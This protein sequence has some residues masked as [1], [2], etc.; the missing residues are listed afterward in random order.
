MNLKINWD[1]MGITTS[2]ACA[3]HC[4]LLPLFITSF[5]ILGIEIIDNQLFEYLMI[6]AAFCVGAY[7][8]FH[9]WKK[10]HHQ[11]QPLL[12]FSLGIGFLICKQIWHSWQLWFLIP[13]VFLIIAGH[14]IN[15]RLCRKANHCHAAD[16]SH[17]K[18]I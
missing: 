13:A 15:Y 6:F 10:H 16:C 9:G 5:P 12:L 1:A 4:A 11:W 7:S 3:I 2:V 8:L 17:E 14:F 18:I